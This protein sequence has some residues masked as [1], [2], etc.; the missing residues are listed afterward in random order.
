MRRHTTAPTN[1]YEEEE[2]ISEFVDPVEIES[3]FSFSF[4][5]T[6]STKCATCVEQ[7]EQPGWVEDSTLLVPASSLGPAGI[8]ALGIVGTSPDPRTHNIPQSSKTGHTAC[9]NSSVCSSPLS[10][11]RISRSTSASTR[12]RRWRRRGAFFGIRTPR[13]FP[14][15]SLLWLELSSELYKPPK[16]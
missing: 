11:P 6:F 14:L 5:S 15:Q 2:T 8:L 16:R 3:T 7:F 4:I 9:K 13:P 10:C 1:Q 12:G